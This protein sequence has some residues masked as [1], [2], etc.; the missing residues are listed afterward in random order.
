MSVEIYGIDDS[1]VYFRPIGVS[2]RRHLKR[3]VK[4]EMNVL[5]KGYAEGK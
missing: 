2:G 5:G 3:H 1:A 4:V